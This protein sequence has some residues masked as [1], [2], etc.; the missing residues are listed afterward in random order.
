MTLYLYLPY[1]AGGSSESEFISIDVCFL[2]EMEN[3]THHI[4]DLA[5]FHL[6]AFANYHALMDENSNAFAIT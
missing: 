5:N 1:V 2:L 6:L 4:V 3:K